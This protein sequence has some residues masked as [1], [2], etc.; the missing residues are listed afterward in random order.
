MRE[1]VQVHGAELVEQS[2]AALLAGQEL[3]S[4]KNLVLGPVAV[5]VEH[6]QSVLRTQ[7][8]PPKAES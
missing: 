6:L 4:S 7:W 2:L 5:L 3:H 1:E 8:L